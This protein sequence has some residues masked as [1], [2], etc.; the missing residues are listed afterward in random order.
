MLR[1]TRKRHIISFPTSLRGLTRYDTQLLTT[2]CSE[3][4]LSFIVENSRVPHTKI[5]DNTVVFSETA[6]F[7]F[8]V[9]VSLK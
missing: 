3:E 9:E 1:K 6:R 4:I 8:S 2:V 7:N 5:K